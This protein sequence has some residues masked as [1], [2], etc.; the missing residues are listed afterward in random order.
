VGTE[1]AAAVYPLI[2]VRSRS[3][4]SGVVA[5]ASAGCA[6]AGSGGIAPGVRGTTTAVAA[7]VAGTTT[8]VAAGVAGTP[9]AV[10]WN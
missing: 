5:L 4:L 3:L 7:G 2:P 1:S 9:A 6:A 8:A 10:G